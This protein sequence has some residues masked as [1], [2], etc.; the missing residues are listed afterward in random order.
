MTPD[1]VL[2][3]DELYNGKYSNQQLAQPPMAFLDKEWQ[4]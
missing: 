3:A 2:H 4:H 1:H